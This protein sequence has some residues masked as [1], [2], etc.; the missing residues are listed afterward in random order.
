VLGL[1]LVACSSDDE[2]VGSDG[3]ENGLESDAAPGVADVEAPPF[4]MEVVPAIDAVVEKLGDDVEFFEVTAN[5]Q[6][7]NVFVAVDDATAAVPYTY[8]DGELQ[9]PAPT[10]TGAEGLTFTRDDVAFD[11]DLVTAG[12]QADLPASTIDAISVYGDGVGATY[13]VAVTSESGGFLDVV[14]TADGLVVSV[15]PV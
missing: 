8:V 7:T 4:V 9:P 5:A 1:G 6:F 12:V 11:P 13:V 14:V 3:D 15:D 10:Q 2:G